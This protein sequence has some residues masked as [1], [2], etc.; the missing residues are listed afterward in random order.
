M[1]PCLSCVD[2]NREAQKRLKSTAAPE[3]KCGDSRTEGSNCGVRNDGHV[4]GVSFLIY[5]L[6]KSVVQYG[7]SFVFHLKYPFKCIDTLLQEGTL[8]P[9]IPL[10]SAPN[11][12]KFRVILCV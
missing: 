7:Q 5:L 1:N 6:L 8:S 9:Q 3:E 4:H 2:L 10:Y 12:L 11:I